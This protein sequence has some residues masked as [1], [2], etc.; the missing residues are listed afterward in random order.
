MKK[1]KLI[2]TNLLLTITLVFSSAQVAKADPGSEPGGP[3]ETSRARKAPE[4]PIDVEI[5]LVI[6]RTVMWHF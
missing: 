1:L 4:A 6:L 5:L 2:I 3:Q